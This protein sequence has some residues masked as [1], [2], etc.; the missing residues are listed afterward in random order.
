MG[1]FILK[2]KQAK[3][4]RNK[5][6]LSML[7][8]VIL[9]IGVIIGVFGI[10]DT[11][12]QLDKSAIQ[13]FTN[14]VNAKTK[15]L[16]RQ[17][18]LWSDM[19]YFQ[20]EI[21]E[22]SKE[23]EEMEELSFSKIMED[24]KKRKTFLKRV[25]N[26]VLNNLR[27]T[28]T[29]GSFII[30]NGED[31]SEEKDAIFLRDLNPNDK[32]DT[33]KDI[34]V[35]AGSSELM[36]KNG[37][38]LDSSWTSRLPTTENSDF[39]YKPFYA[40][41]QYK[42]INAENLGYW[43]NPFRLRSSDIEIITYS[44]PLLDS[45]HNAYGVIGIDIT[46]NYL[47]KYLETNQISIDS[48]AS[49]YIGT[50]KDDKIYQTVLVN[51][52]YYKVRLGSNSKLTVN[53]LEGDNNLYQVKI[54]GQ[55]EDTI[56]TMK[57]LRLY[58][59]NTPFEEEHWVIGALISKLSIYQSSNRFQ[60]ALG[61]A[62]I[63]SFAITVVGASLVV[64]ITLN[65]I[66]MLMKSIDE[67]KQPYDVKLFQ[68]NIREFDDLANKI[69]ELS[70]K[71]YKAGSR[72][73]DILELSNLPLG[74]CEYDEKAEHIFCTYKFMEIAELSM[75]SWNNNYVKKEEFN[76][77]MKFFQKKLQ[78]ETEEI[79]IYQ[80]YNERKINQWLKITNVSSDFGMLI[81]ILDVTHDV[82]EKIKI[83]HD[84]DYDVLTNLFNRRAFARKVI[85]LL[86]DDNCKFGVLSVWDLDNL[87]F[88]NDTYGHD[89]GDKYICL[90]S[91]LFLT[92]RSNNMIIARMSGDEFMI[93][94]Y[95]R[96]N[97]FS[98]E[99]SEELC[100]T[101]TE[102]MFKKL[103][104]IHQKFLEQKLE[105]H[106]G[107][108]LPVSVSAGMVSIEES[109]DYTDLFSYAD[110]SMYEIKKQEKGGIKRFEK[111]RY[112]KDYILVQGVGELNRILTEESIT[113]VFQPIIDLKEKKVYAYEALMRPNSEMLRN[114]A[115]FLR[116]AQAQSKLN[117]VE[118]MTWFHALKQYKELPNR[119]KEVKLFVNSIPNQI[120]PLE[121]R[122]ELCNQYGSMLGN[123][124][125]E[126]TE[127]TQLNKK[128]EKE[129]D[130]F[131]K[132]WNILCA[133]DDYGAGYS[134]TDILVSRKF[135]FIKLDMALIHNIHQFPKR[136]SL[137]EGIIQ[138]CHNNQIKVIAEGIEIKEELD[139][140]ICLGADYAQGYYFAKPSRTLEEIDIEG[141]MAESS[142][143]I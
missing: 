41:S 18:I 125:L 70:N 74:I 66:R 85:E 10:S 128:Y 112:I 96:K 79:D 2:L 135:D 47:N 104:K 40:G 136:Q 143:I 109:R 1:A 117:Q 107:I 83:R 116:V 34:L 118:I 63:I 31:N 4:L 54:K 111:E 101:Q 142:D 35:L 38:P 19:E 72:V 134:N 67:T 11:K 139:Q 13:I 131:C 105:L 90:L 137:V 32:S 93:F 87:K 102:E 6:L 59:S 114:P 113:Y 100:E 30:L 62:C 48:D 69:E 64:T 37:Y 26:I 129:K 91:N 81:L 127:S 27:Y 25:S 65:P 124:V 97:E 141:K 84:R 22:I 50:T 16:E 121:L 21:T 94:L 36:V 115:D 53:E 89:M 76:Q 46:L 132:E 106:D 98:F 138:Y 77:Q 71:V 58:N 110:F 140:I 9:Q 12:A 86:K 95:T 44:Q 15:E 51:Q 23:M 73:A 29:T 56:V 5:M 17:M 43:S 92:Y 80:F 61:I 75:P 45:E 14:S 57:Q 24:G 103:E 3:T 82:E 55:E 60:L 7:A 49:Y 108:V 68:T 39:Y 99:N 78:K 133:L 122:K 126:V 123:V 20:E 8:I 28:E 33:N 119:K 42:E 130:E 120:M 52:N 88:V